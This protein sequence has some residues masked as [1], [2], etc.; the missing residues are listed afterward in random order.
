MFVQVLG[1]NVRVLPLWKIGIGLILAQGCFPVDEVFH[2][3]LI[4]ILV[5]QILMTNGACSYSV[6]SYLIRRQQFQSNKIVPKCWNENPFW[7]WGPKSQFGTSHALKLIWR[8]NHTS[9]NLHRIQQICW[10]N[11]PR[12]LGPLHL[13]HHLSVPQT[14]SLSMI[15]QTN[16]M[17]S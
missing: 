5:I 11:C 12:P 4:S 8:P 2:G 1:L 16:K 13:L 15:I 9:P 3:V 6:T 7:T 14:A 10:T 17:F